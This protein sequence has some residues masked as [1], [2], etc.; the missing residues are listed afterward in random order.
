M[1][2]MPSAEDLAKPAAAEEDKLPSVEECV[3]D[4]IKAG[5]AAGGADRNNADY[6]AAARK[7]DAA[8]SATPGVVR[9]DEYSIKNTT[10]MENALEAA[11]IDITGEI[12][13]AMSSGD[14]VTLYNSLMEQSEEAEKSGSPK[15]RAAMP[16]CMLPPMG[17][18]DTK[19]VLFLTS[20]TEDTGMRLRTLFKSK[21]EKL[22]YLMPI[23]FEA[24]AG[25][26]PAT[27]VS[28][29]AA[30]GAG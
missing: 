9:L 10:E 22:K 19:P 28:G 25:E 13:E 27:E 6:K 2:G 4:L 8:L 15:H 26:E 16:I 7:V 24:A 12:R 3:E 20:A 21:R 14:L 29:G 11:K 18:K 17:D 1:G 5:E 23:G 30:E